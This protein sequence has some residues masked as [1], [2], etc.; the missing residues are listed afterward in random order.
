MAVKSFVDKMVTDSRVKLLQ[1]AIIMGQF[2]NPNVIS[3]YG[4]VKTKDRVSVMIKS[5]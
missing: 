5:I 4:M 2:H 1:E 3:F